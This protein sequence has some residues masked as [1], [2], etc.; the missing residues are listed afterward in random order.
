MFIEIKPQQIL[1]TMSIHHIEI[2]IANSVL[3]CKTGVNMLP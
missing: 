2:L 3:Q 1:L